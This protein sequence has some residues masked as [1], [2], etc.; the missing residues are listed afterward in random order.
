MKLNILYEDNDIIVCIKPAGIATQN[1]HAGTPD[2]VSLLKNHLRSSQ[3]DRQP[4]LAVI[5][6]LD[7]PVTGLLVF[8]KNKK[9]ASGLS[10][11]LTTDGFGKYYLAGLS[12][13]PVPEEGTLTDYLVK[14]RHTNTSHVCTKDT[15]GSRKARLHYKVIKK[16]ENSAI[17]AITLDTGRH[18]QIRVQ[19]SSIGCPVIGDVKYGAPHPGQLQ[20]FACRLTFQ[21]PVTGKPLDFILDQPDILSGKEPFQKQAP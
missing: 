20:L 14:D 3:P 7:Q 12:N 15:P 4:Y 1:N 5:H 21:H 17:V 6:R 18:H 9:A 2:M 13:S 19:M 10:R 8:A 16:T 11:Q